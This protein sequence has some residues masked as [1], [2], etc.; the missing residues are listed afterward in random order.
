MREPS[1][2]AIGD[3]KNGASLWE[4]GRKPRQEPALVTTLQPPSQ[5]SSPETYVVKAPR[6]QLPDIFDDFSNSARPFCPIN[7]RLFALRNLLD[8]RYKIEDPFLMHALKHFQS[9][10]DM[11]RAGIQRMRHSN[12]LRLPRAFVFRSHHA[13]LSCP[14]VKDSF[15]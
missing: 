2:L 11:R 12:L 10:I 13:A 9:L 4:G 15:S 5:R 8:F 3:Q 1:D 6:P 7:D 14:R